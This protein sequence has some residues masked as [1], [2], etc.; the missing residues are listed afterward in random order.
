M[1][2]R[3]NTFIGK[4]N[5]FSSLIILRELI[6]IFRQTCLIFLLL[7]FPDNKILLKFIIILVLFYSIVINLKH[8]PRI[9]KIFNILD[10]ISILACFFLACSCYLVG[11]D[12]PIF[13][14]L[15]IALIFVIL[16]ISFFLIL[17][18][19]LSKEFLLRYPKKLKKIFGKLRTK[20]EERRKK[21]SI[22]QMNWKTT[23][24]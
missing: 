20:E 12:F 10:V 6:N 15:L 5:E 17:M 23:K 9:F 18:F 3:K 14:N 11:E 13:I 21:H 19:K 16:H 22:I 8:C 24:I 7:I 2:I 1:R 4:K